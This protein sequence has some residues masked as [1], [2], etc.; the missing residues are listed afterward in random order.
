MTFQRSQLAGYRNIEIIEMG[1]SIII[2]DCTAVI[3]ETARIIYCLLQLKADKEE[4]SWWHPIDHQTI[5]ASIFNLSLSTNR[6]EIL[7][8]QFEVFF[9][10]D[11][12]SIVAVTIFFNKSM[13]MIRL[14]YNPDVK[15]IHMLFVF[16][17]YVS[18]LIKRNNQRRSTK[19]WYTLGL[20]QLE[21]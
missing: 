15:I 19:K 13:Y 9:F 18:K 11:F 20:F 5:C 2:V 3:I 6:M 8:C 21:N 16:D 1:H 14:N 10:L 12:S 7:K 4:R 17:I